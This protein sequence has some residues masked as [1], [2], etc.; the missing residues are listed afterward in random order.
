MSDKE[1]IHPQ[2]KRMAAEL[3]TTGGLTKREHFAALCLQAMLSPL[4]LPLSEINT[5]ALADNAVLMADELIR[6]LSDK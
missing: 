5:S 6:S 2:S 1:F 4:T 3:W